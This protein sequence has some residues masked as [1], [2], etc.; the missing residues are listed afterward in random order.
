MSKLLLLPTIAP[1]VAF[2]QPTTWVP[3]DVFENYLEFNNMGNGI[4]D[5][6]YVFTAIISSVDSLN[7]MWYGGIRDLTGMEGFTALTGVYCSLDELTGLDES[8]NTAITYVMPATYDTG[9][10]QRNFINE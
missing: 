7:V 2:G 4:Y 3:D 5:D 9:A 6:D 8:N 10:L 1:C